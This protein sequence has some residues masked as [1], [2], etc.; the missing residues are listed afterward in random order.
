MPGGRHGS[1]ENVGGRL[2]FERKR[3]KAG[4]GQADPVVAL[5]SVRNLRTQK[6]V[7]GGHDA[8]PNDDGAERFNA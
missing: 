3:Q 7:G 1:R 6:A 5:R 2:E 4:K 8:N